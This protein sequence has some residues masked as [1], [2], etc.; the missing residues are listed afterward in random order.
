VL[1]VK[2]LQVYGVMW[3]MA[4][5]WKWP[6]IWIAWTQWTVWF[7]LDWFSTSSR[8]AL[9]GKSQTDINKW[10]ELDGYLV[11]YA[12]PFIIVPVVC[13]LMTVLYQQLLKR[14]KFQLQ[15]YTAATTALLLQ[16]L[17]LSYMPVCLAVSRVFYCETNGELSVD[18]S[19]RCW[20]G[21]HL[22]VSICC[23]LLGVPLFIGLPA[24]IYRYIDQTVVYD[25]ESDHERRLQA[26]ELSYIFDLD[27]VWL[28][29][30]LWL[31]S[32][33]RLQGAY[34]SFYQLIFQ[35]YCLVLFLCFRFSIAAQSTLFC[36]GCV[37]CFLLTLRTQ[38]YRNP[39]SNVVACVLGALLVVNSAFGMFNAYG[40]QNSVMVSG[41][42]TVCLLGFN[43]AGAMCLIIVVIWCMCSGGYTWP[44][45]RTLH[46]IRSSSLWPVV[47]RWVA[48]VR[49]GYAVDADCYLCSPECVDILGLE[50]RIRALRRAWLDA[51]SVGSVFT[52]ILSDALEQLLRTHA[53]MAPVALRGKEVWDKAWISGGR[54]AFMKRERTYKLVPPRKRRIITKLLALKA[55]IGDRSIRRLDDDDP[56][57]D[58]FGM[59]M[60]V[61]RQL[62]SMLVGSTDADDM[63]HR[64][65]STFAPK[66]RLAAEEEKKRKEMWSSDDA[67]EKSAL[68]VRDLTEKT[69][70]FLKTCKKEKEEMDI[71]VSLLRQWDDIVCQYEKHEL[72]GG[73]GFSDTNAEEWFTYRHIL[74]NI[75]REMDP[76]VDAESEGSIYSTMDDQFD[77]AEDVVEPSL[78][79]EIQQQAQGMLSLSSRD[80]SDKV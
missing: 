32:S 1:V 9:R 72:E 73:A 21:E 44:S 71:V 34:F 51:S 22:V 29:L 30:Q 78:T 13:I 7:N 36:L 12:L 17:Q 53:V 38:P 18:P 40:V 80:V 37:L 39:S 3:N 77:Q 76:L 52:V 64:R 41:T 66:S 11:I 54:E 68:I 23:L 10:G 63:H 60:T 19:K 16:F 50:E 74:S 48:A 4:Q 61:R 67:H 62:T 28:R 2:Y 55:F 24:L 6:Y 70:A 59:S 14:R 45:H 46:R 5:V 42:E 35:A 47:E 75:L 49:E 31:T 15:G 20:T 27:D 43:S 58:E 8:G 65:N 33:F 79:E 57:Y 69:E 56:D 25:L 26:W